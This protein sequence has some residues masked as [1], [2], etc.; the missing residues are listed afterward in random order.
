MNRSLLL[1]YLTVKEN[2]YLK[3]QIVETEEDLSTTQ[4]NL[5]IYKEKFQSQNLDIVELK[6]LNSELIASKTQTTDVSPIKS[7]TLY[8]L[9]F[10]IN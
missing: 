7:A 6:I 8:F 1:S 9:R 10:F 3:Q 2:A 5:L 4:K